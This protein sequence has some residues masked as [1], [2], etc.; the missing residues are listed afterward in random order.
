[1]KYLLAGLIAIF[2]TGCASFNSPALVKPQVNSKIKTPTA[3]A[4]VDHRPYVIDGDKQPNFEGLNRA[5]VG[6][7]YSEKTGNEENLSD[8][9][10]LILKSGL[11]ASNSDINLISTQHTDS[12]SDVEKTLLASA[13]NYLYIELVEMKYDFQ[14]AFNAKVHYDVNMKYLDGTSKQVF[15]KNFSGAESFSKFSSGKNQIRNN[16]Q[17]IYKGLIESILNDPDFQQFL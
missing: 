2:I 7:P 1:M 15:S 14:A 8:Y 11:L 9:I 5:A 6:I 13:E 3:I 16:V 12:N 17:N 10:G 4:V